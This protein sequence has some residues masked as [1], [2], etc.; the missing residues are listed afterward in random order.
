MM[1]WEWMMCSTHLTTVG[2]EWRELRGTGV[3]DVRESSDP[4]SEGIGLGLV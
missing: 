4:S 1:G 3:K 2:D